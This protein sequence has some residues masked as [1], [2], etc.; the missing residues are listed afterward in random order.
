MPEPTRPA[1]TQEMIRLYDE[2][3]HLTLDRRGFLD[4][5]TR[6]AGGSVAAA[7][8]VP[9]LAAN[10]AQA[11]IVAA[12]DARIT[13]KPVTFPGPGGVQ[14]SGYLAAP[15]DAAGK[16]PSVLVIHENRGLNPHIED[17]T[18]RLALEGFLG[19]IQLEHVLS[20]EE[21]MREAVDHEVPR[22][23]V[24]VEL[25][26]GFLELLYRLVPAAFVELPL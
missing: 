26:D 17:V 24:V 10:K 19:L 21:R 1:V 11:A 4:K 6:L 12:D 9:L 8:I 25:A 14:L 7:A 3:T 22:L 18:R 5:L 23:L 13:T 20:C 16:L 15:N 2:Y